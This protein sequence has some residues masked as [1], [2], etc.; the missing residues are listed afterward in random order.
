MLAIIPL[1]GL[2]GWLM[3]AGHSIGTKPQAAQKITG[4]NLSP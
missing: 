1:T 4:S 2:L 3:A